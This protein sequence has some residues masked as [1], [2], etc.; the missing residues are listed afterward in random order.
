MPGRFEWLYYFLL[1]F[2]VVVSVL[3]FRRLRFF[4]GRVR[5][6]YSKSDIKKTG[7]TLARKNFSEDTYTAKR[8]DRS[9][10]MLCPDFGFTSA[11]SLQNQLDTYDFSDEQVRHII[12]EYMIGNALNE[13]LRNNTIINLNS[14]ER[15][16][17]SMGDDYLIHLWKQARSKVEG[18][19]G[20]YWFQ[21]I[22]K[23]LVIELRKRFSNEYRNLFSYNS[24]SNQFVNSFIDIPKYICKKNPRFIKHLLSTFIEVIDQ[25]GMTPH[26]QMIE[27]TPLIGAE[28][29]MAKYRFYSSKKER[30]EV[31]DPFNMMTKES[32][33]MVW[34]NTSRQD[35][36][37]YYTWK[38]YNLMVIFI[39]LTLLLLFAKVLFK[40]PRF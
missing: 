32:G 35:R 8:M 39:V 15:F 13:V 23:Q 28:G 7:K 27:G 31:G 26:L 20:R 12:P 10:E 11:L 4:K 3:L 25:V 9:Y 19:E 14:F 21:K 22:G 2:C 40:W 16:V 24:N 17:C 29:S 18:Q 6:K 34:R 30:D 33:Q 37:D 36:S 1:I 38:Y 5:S